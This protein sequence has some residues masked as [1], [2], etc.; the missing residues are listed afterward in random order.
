ML[1][2]EENKNSKQLKRVVTSKLSESPVRK[3]KALTPDILLNIA[4]R[5]ANKTA[6]TARGS[7]QINQF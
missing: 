2:G 6:T 3:S 7:R 5:W 4:R 1:R